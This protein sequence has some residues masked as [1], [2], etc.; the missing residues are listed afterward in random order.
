MIKVLLSGFLVG[1]V[2]LVSSCGTGAEQA[3][4][5]S[6]SPVQGGTK[7]QVISAAA[8]D[9]SDTL[10]TN[11]GEVYK[12]VKIKEITPAGIKITHSSGVSG[13][14]YEKLSKE[15]QNELG[16]FNSKEA[17][18]Y[19]EKVRVQQAKIADA[20]EARQFK[21]DK[22]KRDRDA[23][24]LAASKNRRFYLSSD[25]YRRRAAASAKAAA[26]TRV[27][28]ERTPSIPRLTDL[29]RGEMIERQRQQ[30][31]MRRIIGNPLD[32]DTLD[33]NRRL[34]QLELDNQLREQEELA[35]QLHDNLK[36]R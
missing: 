36:M 4:S 3:N 16:G 5:K 9:Y 15:L 11:D 2:S 25:E 27:L 8:R 32:L 19:R 14:P 30:E 13:I 10:I 28:L 34:K 23:K 6:Q 29:Q 7:Q 22:L 24:L 12:S 17:E 1:F 26:R 18:K 35:R 31:Q 20:F 33:M 21:N